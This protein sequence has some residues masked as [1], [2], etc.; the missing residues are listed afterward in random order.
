MRN[1]ESSRLNRGSKIILATMLGVMFVVSSGWAQT[2][3]QKKNTSRIEF[4]DVPLKM[5]IKNLAKQLKLNV[6]FDDSFRDIAKYNL[7]LEDVTL[8]S[9]MNIIL[10]QNKLS[11]RMIE[12]H[13]LFISFDQEA[14]QSR[15]AAYPK[16]SEKTGKK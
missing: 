16:W 13:T 6:V 12:E 4:T 3:E 1:R 11:A 7:E 14:I 8:E 9:A 5:V 15:L 2:S 10:V